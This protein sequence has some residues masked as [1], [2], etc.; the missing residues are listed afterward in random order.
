[1][2]RNYTML[3]IPIQLL[4]EVQLCFQ[5]VEEKEVNVPDLLGYSTVPF[6]LTSNSCYTSTPPTCLDGVDKDNFTFLCLLNTYLS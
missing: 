5:I 1:M 2:Q 6:V 4:S 3:F